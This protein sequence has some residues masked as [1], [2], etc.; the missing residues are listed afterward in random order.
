[1]AEGVQLF[2]CELVAL[3]LEGH[4]ESCELC[5]IRVEATC[6]GLVGHLAVALDVR[7]HVAGGQQSPLR[8]QER[9]QRELPDQ[10]V[11][12]MGHRPR[13]YSGVGGA[14]DCATG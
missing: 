10:L 9:D 4:S 1:R 13:A 7:L 11:R 8:H 14:E 2:A 3:G 6:E 12:V 5:P